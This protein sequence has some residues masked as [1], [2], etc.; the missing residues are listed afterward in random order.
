MDG[1]T[2]VWATLTA[3]ARRG[4]LA[5]VGFEEAQDHVG[6]AGAGAAGTDALHIDAGAFEEEES[7]VGKPFRFGEP[8]L[9]AQLHQIVALMRLVLLNH[10]AGGMMRLRQFDRGVG[11]G[12]SPVGPA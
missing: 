11:E 6:D 12:A 8:G 3:F 5:G 4:F 2:E 7:F 1:G 10:G 9:G